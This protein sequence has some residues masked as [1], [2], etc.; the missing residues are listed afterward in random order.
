MKSRG[1]GLL[2]EKARVREA[3]MIEKRNCAIGKDKINSFALIL[4]KIASSTKDDTE[5]TQIILM[6][7]F[8]LLLSS[9]HYLFI[10]V[11]FCTHLLLTV[12]QFF[13]LLSLLLKVIM[14]Q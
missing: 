8:L 2:R 13:R 5:I 11:F 12:K 3:L 10:V 4:L 9:V 1:I 6:K 7:Q 14:K